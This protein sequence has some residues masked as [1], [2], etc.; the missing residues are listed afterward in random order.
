MHLAP[1]LEHATARHSRASELLSVQLA[2]D[3]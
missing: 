3:V 2:P 1:S